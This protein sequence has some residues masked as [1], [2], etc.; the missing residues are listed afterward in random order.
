MFFNKTEAHA[1]KLRGKEFGFLLECLRSED[2]ALPAEI[3]PA[4]LDWDLFLQ[5]TQRHSVVPLVHRVLGRYPGIPLAAWQGLDS[6]FRQNTC[7]SL[8]LT[9]ELMRLLEGFSERGIPVLPYKGPTVAQQLYGDVALR[10]FSDLDLLVRVSDLQSATELLQSLGYA[11]DH[12]VPPARRVA[13]LAFASE[14]MFRRGDCAARVELQ[15]RIAP[16]YFAVDFNW[17]L[18]WSS[19]VFVSIGERQVPALAPE[20]LLLV[21]SAHGAKHCWESL[22]WIADIAQ[23]LRKFPQLDWDATFE[24][25]RSLGIERLL[26]M[27]LA[28]AEQFLGAPLPAATA[29]LIAS[30]EAI[31]WLCREVECHLALEEVSGIPTLADHWFSLRARERWRDRLRYVARLSLTPNPQD[32]AV[33]TL[34]PTLGSLYFCIRPLRLLGRTARWAWRLLFRHRDSGHQPPND[35]YECD[36]DRHTNGHNRRQHR[37]GHE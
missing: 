32:W 37:H 3:I 19:A 24:T 31:A 7:R 15:W 23:L 22:L 35:T 21:L 26:F 13:H 12:G 29:D 1:S 20:V 9:A 16:A 28:L 27:A 6:L 5:A 2:G 11:A 34:P 14:Q 4:D 30:D 36:Y 10:S 18:L 17:N 33:L 25:A 8:F